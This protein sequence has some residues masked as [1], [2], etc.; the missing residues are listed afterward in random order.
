MEER[1]LFVSCLY[2]LFYPIILR[3]NI[4]FNITMKVNSELIKLFL[5]DYL[6]KYNVT[7]ETANEN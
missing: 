4:T 5:S 3:H 1:D 7:K 2:S 6:I